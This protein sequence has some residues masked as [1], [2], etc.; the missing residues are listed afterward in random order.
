MICVIKKLM[1]NCLRL[2]LAFS[3][4]ISLLSA[5]SP[6]SQRNYSNYTKPYKKPINRNSPNIAENG[7]Y[8]GQ[9]S[10]KTKKPKD[11]YVKGYYRKNGTYVRGHYRS[12][13]R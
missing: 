5:A 9:V 13:R 11:T 7:S 1:H 8:R 2:F 6:A 3:I 4:G 12:R 10:E